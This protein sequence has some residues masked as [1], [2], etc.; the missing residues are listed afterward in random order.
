MSRLVLPILLVALGLACTGT[1]HGAY[2]FD[3]SVGEWELAGSEQVGGA[4][5]DRYAHAVHAERLEVWEVARPAPAESAVPFGALAPAARILPP[6]GVPT[7][8]PR[9][10]G[11]DELSGTQ[12]YWVSQFGRVGDEALQAAVFVVP[13]GR[14]HFV[15]RLASR[16]GDVEQCRAWLR[17]MLLRDFRF[18]PPS[19]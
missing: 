16:E 7:A 12:G 10:L 18:P 1:L 17:D 5:H 8:V 3:T 13:R 19:R 15:V 11:D 9:T 4:V 2:T 14:R 6:L